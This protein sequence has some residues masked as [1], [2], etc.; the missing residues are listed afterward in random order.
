MSQGFI[1]FLTIGAIVAYFMTG[2]VGEIQDADDDLL[3]DQMMVEKEDMSYHKQDV[4]GQTVL[5]FKN[6]SFAKELGIWNRSPLH[7]EF[8]HYFPNFLLMKSF[9][10]DRVVDKSFQQKFI[11]KVIKIEDAYFAG[12][13]SLM[14]AKIKLNSIRA[15]D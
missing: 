15:D 8:M 9:I 6:E 3:T 10:N 5:V 14:E 2:F 7:Q 11:Q 12:E 4:I 13:I 1:I